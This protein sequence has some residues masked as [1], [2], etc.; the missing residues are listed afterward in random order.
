[1]TYR[2]KVRGASR[3]RRARLLL[4]ILFTK[5]NHGNRKRLQLPK[6]RNPCRAHLGEQNRSV[7]PVGELSD[8]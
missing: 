7:A 1:M 5:V 6:V 2:S 3:S 4:G 8:L